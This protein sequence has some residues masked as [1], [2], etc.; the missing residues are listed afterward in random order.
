MRSAQR[1]M[2]AGMLGLQA[3]VLFLLGVTLP[4]V[5]DAVSPGGGIA[6]G[7]GL[8]ALCVL[9]AGTMRNRVGFLLGW[10]VQVLS[11]ALGFVIPVM[12]ALGAVFLALYAGAYVLGGRIDRERAERTARADADAD[13]DAGTP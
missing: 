11:L 8:G 13:A 10:G 7:L 5:A 12:F 3:V 4:S 1:S 2:C 9:A 6:I